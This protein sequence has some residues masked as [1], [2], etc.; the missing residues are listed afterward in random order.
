MLLESSDDDCRELVKELIEKSDRLKEEATSPELLRSLAAPMAGHAGLSLVG[1]NDEA[2]RKIGEEAIETIDNAMNGKDTV[3][4]FLSMHVKPLKALLE[5]GA[6]VDDGLVEEMLSTPGAKES[7]APR[8]ASREITYEY[9]DAEQAVPEVL[10][11]GGASEPLP[12]AEGPILGPWTMDDA[13]GATDNKGGAGGAKK[14]TGLLKKDSLSLAGL[15]NVLDGVVDTPQ[16]MLIMTTNHPGGFTQR[17]ATVC[18]C[19]NR[20]TC[21]LS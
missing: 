9:A 14:W 10:L 11:Q 8:E 16:R 18:P 5:Q 3:D 12:A 2:L 7:I 21:F 1:S 20:L 15:L 17:I 13:K 19:H 4:R 6:K